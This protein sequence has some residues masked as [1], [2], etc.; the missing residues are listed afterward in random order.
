MTTHLNGKDSFFM[1]FNKGLNDGAPFPP[2]GAGN[3]L[4]PD[5]LKTAYLWEDIFTKESLA[6]IIEK[7]AQVLT[8]KDPI[9]RNPNGN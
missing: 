5:G 6:N 8:E 7:Y 1:P 2:F 9:P 4:N 3:P